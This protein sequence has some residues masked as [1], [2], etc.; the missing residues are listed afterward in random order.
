MTEKPMAHT[1]EEVDRMVSTCAAAGVPLSCG[2][3]STTHPSFAVAKRLLDEGAADGLAV[4][5]RPGAPGLRLG[6]EDGEIVFDLGQTLALVER[7]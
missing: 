2:S 3:I 1:L 5:F 4:H 6:G 7:H